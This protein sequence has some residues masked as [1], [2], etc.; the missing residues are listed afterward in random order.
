MAALVFQLILL[1]LGFKFTVAEG[2]FFF[3]YID[4]SLYFI[5]FILKIRYTDRSN[6]RTC[7]SR[8]CYNWAS[9]HSNSRVLLYKPEEETQQKVCHND[10]TSLPPPHVRSYT[11]HIATPFKRSNER[12]KRSGH[13]GPY[14]YGWIV[15]RINHSHTV[16]NVFQYLLWYKY[17]KSFAK[18]AH[19]QNSTRSRISH[20]SRQ[21]YDEGGEDDGTKTIRVVHNSLYQSMK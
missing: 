10:M 6:N 13:N 21:E 20:I 14:N 8:G 1:S 2:K 15:N 16:C 12:H 9:Y 11:L 4:Y 3:A 7:G 17:S 19:E 5:R 18:S